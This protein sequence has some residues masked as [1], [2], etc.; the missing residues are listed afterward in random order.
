VGSFT[1]PDLSSQCGHPNRTVLTHPSTFNREVSQD[2]TRAVAE[3][4]KRA[5]SA[6]E[7]TTDTAEQSIP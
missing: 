5:G 3:E 2:V 1:R 7:P 4:A 6:R